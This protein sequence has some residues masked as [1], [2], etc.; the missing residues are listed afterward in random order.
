MMWSN[1]LDILHYFLL[2]A[3]SGCITKIIALV[4]NEIIRTK[5]KNKFLN[6]YSFCFYI[7]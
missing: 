3:Y 5:E 1:L 4:R 2:G 6:N 7:C